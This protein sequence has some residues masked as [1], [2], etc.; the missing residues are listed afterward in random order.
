M[1]LTALGKIKNTIYNLQNNFKNKEIDI[2]IFHKELQTQKEKAKELE[3]YFEIHE[4]EAYK[5]GAVLREQLD[6]QQVGKFSE[7]YAVAQDWLDK[8]FYINKHG[9]R[10]NNE[11][12]EDAGNFPNRRAAV[13]QGDTWHFITEDGERLNDEE[14]VDACSFSNGRAKVQQGDIKFY[15][16][17]NG[18]KI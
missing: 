15:I 11:E 10:L 1:Q 2:E 5:L 16:D 12:Y 6:L 8:Y 9:E 4:S 17:I 13:K 3:R 14:Y 7:G 18:K